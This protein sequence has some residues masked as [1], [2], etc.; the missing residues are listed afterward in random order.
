MNYPEVPAILYKH[1]W[2]K[3]I[4][5]C[6]N[7]SVFV[8]VCKRLLSLQYNDG[9]GLPARPRRDPARFVVTRYVAICYVDTS[10]VGKRPDE[11]NGIREGYIREGARSQSRSGPHVVPGGGRA[12][13]ATSRAGPASGGPEGAKAPGAGP[14]PY[15]A[16]RTIV[17]RVWLIKRVFYQSSAKSRI[18]AKV[19]RIW[20]PVPYPSACAESEP[21]RCCT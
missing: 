7:T 20:S 4:R 5:P 18:L 12:D 9:G 3:I 19:P 8:C 21:A 13:R 17:W 1:K 10:G 15:G 16:A 2:H 6:I 14:G 11:C